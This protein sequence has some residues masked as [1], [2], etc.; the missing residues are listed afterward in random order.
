MRGLFYIVR[1]YFAKDHDNFAVIET[2]AEREKN[3]C[4]EDSAE[5]DVKLE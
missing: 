5:E 2:Q 3:S 1:Q 4:S